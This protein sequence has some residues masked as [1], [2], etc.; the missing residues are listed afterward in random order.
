MG[1]V[2]DRAIEALNRNDP[3]LPLADV[4]RALVAAPNDARLW[5]VKGLMHRE[6]DRR[7]LAIPALARAAALA[8][9]DPLIVHGHAQTLLEAGLPSVEAFARML[10]LDPANA[11]A[12]RGL[13]AA[14]VAEGRID[15]AIQGVDQVLRGSP[16]WT[17]GHAL[18]ANLRWSSGERD[19][20]ARSFDEALA[21]HPNSLELRRDQLAALLQAEQYDEALSRIEQGQTLFGPHP[22][23][24]SGEAAIRSELGQKERADLLFAQLAPFEEP[25][26]D[27][28]WVRHLLRTGRAAE[29]LPVLDH[30]LSTGDQAVFWPYAVAAWRLTGD[31]RLDW[32]QGD[33]RL[34]GVY[35]LSDSLP[36]L[37][38][39]AATLRRLH[40][41]KNE[42]FAQS[43]R[44]GTQTDGHLFQ[45]IEPEIVAVREAV[46]NAVRAH[47]EQLP[48]FDADHPLLGRRPSKIEF[49]G[50]WS[51]R[52]QASGYH[53]NHFH[54]MG[55]L[56]SAL[57][58][59][60]PP[61]S[62]K[63]GKGALA[64]G[65]PQAQ[66]GLELAPT[67]IID[68]KPGRLVLFP[69]FM[70]HGTRPFESGERI[71]IAFDVA[72]PAA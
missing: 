56:S 55:W 31:P 58:I 38:A 34:V 16:L 59:V 68:P 26:R 63:G 62:G 10:K 19:R 11:G 51:V 52:L 67:R 5:H 40:V 21:D 12:V 28:R 46:R 70:W 47:S 71:T 8:P 23:F 6:Q 13:A 41:T 7:E 42:P 22:L 43:V 64:L 9:S 53:S 25:S 15:A 24:T 17:E 61:D 4:D 60:L 18:L 50:A 54:L 30:W 44:G 3:D 66:L 32:L 37:D 39:L 1:D 57:Y 14:L 69:S 27:V 65:E 2:L 36:P 29:T 35:D 49:S 48:P 72:P 33:E 45:R 20:F